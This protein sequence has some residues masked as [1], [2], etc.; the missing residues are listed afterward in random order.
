MSPHGPFCPGGTVNP[1]IEKLDVDQPPPN[2]I[3]DVV[4][5]ARTP[6]SAFRRGRS[7]SANSACDVSDGYFAAG[8]A[9]LNTS[10]FF[11]SNPGSTPCSLATLLISNPAPTSSVRE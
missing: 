7:C 8:S 10:T 5:A 6:G 1:S 9:T 4:P 3:T 2:G 11:G